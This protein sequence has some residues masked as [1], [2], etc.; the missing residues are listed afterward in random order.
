LISSQAI[1]AVKARYLH[2][3]QLRWEIDLSDSLLGKGPSKRDSFIFFSSQVFGGVRVKN[4]MA[5]Q[6][7]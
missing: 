5:H 2:S 6:R 3:E 4:F 1:V 7:R